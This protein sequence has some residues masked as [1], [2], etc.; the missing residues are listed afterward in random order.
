MDELELL[1]S[2]QRIKTKLDNN[3]ELTDNEYKIFASAIFAAAIGFIETSLNN[4]LSLFAD[5]DEWHK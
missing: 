5:K 3:E 4:I 1:E 2:L